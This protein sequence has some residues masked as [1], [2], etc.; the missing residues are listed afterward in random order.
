MKVFLCSL[1]LTETT[2]MSASERRKLPASNLPK[3]HVVWMWSLVSRAQCLVSL[4]SS[5]KFTLLSCCF[6]DM[7]GCCRNSFS[8]QMTPNYMTVL[9][10][11]QYGR[12]IKVIRCSHLMYLVC[13]G[14]LKKKN[15]KCAKDVISKIMN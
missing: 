8:N 5:L 13:L 7:D 6:S 3:E 10:P 1:L 15:H 2:F 12:F 11:S 9:T 4:L 14:D